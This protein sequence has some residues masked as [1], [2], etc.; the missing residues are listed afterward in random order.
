M[1]APLPLDFPTHLSANRRELLQTLAANNE[2]RHGDGLL[3]MVLT[4]SAGR[5][6][7]TERSDLDVYVVLTD[8]AMAD[9][10]T[11]RSPAVDEIPIPLSELEEVP[12]YGT[13]GWWGRWACAWVPILGDRT[14][15]KISR[16]VRRN[17]ILHEHEAMQILTTHDRLDGWINFAYRALKNDR[18]GRQVET[19]LDAAE[20]M[21]WL[22]DVIF[23]LNRRV[24]PYQKYL[25]WELREHPLPDWEADELIG[26]LT[27]TLRGDPGAIRVSFAKVTELCRADDR[28]RGVDTLG[29]IIRDWGDELTLFDDPA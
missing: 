13:E 22:L 4:G 14:G 10:E 5:G 19:M 27:S 15:G 23:T 8:E 18:D 7:A 21:P 11:T 1:T 20:S 28:V 12:A 26:L 29:S 6:I 3:G 25:P 24:R 16:A 2:A 17:A 9:R